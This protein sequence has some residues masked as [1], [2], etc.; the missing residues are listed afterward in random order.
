MHL[1]AG[2][3]FAGFQGLLAAMQ[4]VND[5]DASILVNTFYVKLLAKP[6]P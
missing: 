2:L 5:A 4:A 1:A 6:A 3:Q